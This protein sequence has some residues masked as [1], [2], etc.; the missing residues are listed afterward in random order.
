[1]KENRLRTVIGNMGLLG[2][3]QLVITD[4]NSVFYLTGHSIAP[5][6]R[7]YALLIKEDGSADLFVN[8][9]FP[10][11]EI[12]GLK[13]HYHQDCEDNLA[14]LAAAVR[15]GKLGVDKFWAARFLLGLLEKRPD[16]QPVLGSAP[17]DQARNFKD[18]EEVELMR[19]ASAVNDA[20]VGDAIKSVDP[21]ISERQMV[22]VVG[23][24]HVKHGADAATDQLICYGANCAEPHHESDHTML[25]PGDS[26]IF[27]IYTPV[28]RYWCDMTRTVFYQSVTEEQ[29]QVY[30]LVRE[31]NAAGIAAV[32]PGVQMCDIDAAARQVIEDAGYGQYFTH[33]LGHGIGLDVHEP[34]DCSCVNQGL[35]EPGMCFSVEPGVYLP[36]RFGV[37]IEDLVV[38]TETGVEVLN[39]FP[40]ELQVIG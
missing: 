31:A 37:R 35:A 30:E 24:L 13:I 9:L 38:V 21:A 15:P 11:P 1:M 29:R 5:G 18:A 12:A 14:Q 34:P 7:L 26:I 17:V 33:R 19:R 6:E 8:Q 2:L 32:K 20:T 28:R 23:N 10:Q 39:K 22:S 36:G 27:D 16:L 25:K 40:K 4:P 3:S